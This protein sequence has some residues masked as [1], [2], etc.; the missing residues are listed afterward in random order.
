MYE[1][2]WQLERKPFEP[3]VDVGAYYPGEAHQAAL[4]KL[5]YAIECRSGGALLAGA[6]GSGK[7]ML[8][9]LL[10]ERMPE[11]FQPFVHL[12]F[13][14]MSAAELLAWL[15]AEFEHRAPGA[16]ATDDSVRRIQ[17]FLAE[18]A[19]AGRHAVLAI[20]EAHLL[21]SPRTLET[22]RLLLNFE[23][24]GR[25]G[26]TLLLVGQPMLIPM[27]ERLPQLDERMGVKC[28]L[29]P[30]T[31]EETMSYVQHRL[32]LAGAQSSMFTS[33][34]LETVH[35]LSHG[36]PRR[37]NRLCDLALLIAFADEQAMIEEAHI[38]AVSQELVTVEPD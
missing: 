2:Y 23:T 36:M 27:V 9:R 31:V 11:E 19:A 33:G 37:I 8:V 7:T 16:A 6:G 30:L 13:P 35:R 32:A 25:P 26:M 3:G 38:E 18:N 10:A 21:D 17:H 4:L 14:Q 29:R 5:R 22:L 15:A 1:A 12:V 24:S 20:D 34:A 28:L